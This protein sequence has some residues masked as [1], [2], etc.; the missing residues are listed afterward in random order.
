MSARALVRV[1]A[2]LLVCPL[3]CCEKEDTERPPPVHCG[4][5]SCGE[6]PP[7]TP[8]GG[9]R[10]GGGGSD[11][12]G[13]DATSPDAGTAADQ[14]RGT[15]ITVTNV[16]AR[17]G[18]ALAG[19]MVSVEGAGSTTSG[20]TG[21]FTI[22]DVTARPPLYVTVAEAGGLV[23]SQTLATS[24]ADARVFA[25]ERGTLVD[26]AEAMGAT[27]NGTSGALFLRVVDSTG[28]PRD[29][30][31]VTTPAIGIGPFY[32]LA[33]RF[34]RSATLTDVAGAIAIYEV[35]PGRPSVCVR[36]AMETA[37]VCGEV[38]I[39]ADSATFTTI[40]LP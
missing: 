14:V 9:G 6:L 8:G 3:A 30:A 19:A 34:E 40:V 22:A 2:I 17:A 33:G 27:H 35:P 10:D 25:I 21:Q 24:R 26:E 18:A 28:V 13:A 16:V 36:D 31:V 5:P 12:A 4:D 32:D 29:G 20:P 23:Q 15:V 1:A 7:A 38:P 37:E 39:E 11:A